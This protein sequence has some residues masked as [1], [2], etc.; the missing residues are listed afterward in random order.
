MRWAITGVFTARV[1]PAYRYEASAT[2]DVKSE[3]E[4]L[5]GSRALSFPARSNCRS[6]V[7]GYG[8]E[9]QTLSV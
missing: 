7:G 9:P 6:M 3:K 2:I 4:A 5:T 1:A 8:F